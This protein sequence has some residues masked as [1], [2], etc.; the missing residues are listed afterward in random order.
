MKKF[1]LEDNYEKQVQ[2]DLRKV[3]FLALFTGYETYTLLK[4]LALT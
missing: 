4:E 3:F 2:V 1:N